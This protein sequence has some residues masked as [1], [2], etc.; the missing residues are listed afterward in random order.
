MLLSFHELAH[1]ASRMA[2]AGGGV[3]YYVGAALGGTLPEAR[4]SA[5]SCEAAHRF[6]AGG[7]DRTHWRNLVGEFSF[8]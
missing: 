6:R 3:G 2:L 5:T 1:A 8:A 7:Q 4:I